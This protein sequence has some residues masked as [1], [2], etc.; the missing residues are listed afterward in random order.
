MSGS[1]KRRQINLKYTED[2][3]LKCAQYIHSR[4]GQTSIPVLKY[5]IEDVIDTLIISIPIIIIGAITTPHIWTGLLVIIAFFTLRSYSG[6]F[7]FA[8]QSRC[9][10]V[11]ILVIMISIYMP[12]TYWYN[13]LVENS[14]ALLLVTIFAPSGSKAKEEYHRRHKVIAILI[15]S[16]NFFIQSGLLANVFFIQALTTPTILQRI[17]DKYKL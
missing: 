17:F 11:S 7:H 15:V 2:V 4:S 16:S 13:G 10:I 5:A 3:A 9:L 12:V 6:G 1:R 8:S 14:I